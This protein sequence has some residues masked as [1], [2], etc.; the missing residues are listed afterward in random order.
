VTKK[1][2]VQIV[3]FTEEQAK[4]Y[5]MD[6]C[7]VLIMAQMALERGGKGRQFWGRFDL[8]VAKAKQALRPTVEE[9]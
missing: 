9:K 1:K 3:L 6:A 8:A 7:R 2:P 5:A 4:L